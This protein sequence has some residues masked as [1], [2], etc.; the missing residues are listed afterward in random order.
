MILTIPDV[1]QGKDY[2]CG[3]AC[4][5]A[6]CGMNG[7]TSRGP[8]PLANAIQGL[9]PDTVEA[10]FRST[11]WTI[12]SG[13][14]TVDDLKHFADT[15]RPVMCPATIEQEGHWVVSAGV[16]RGRVH[17]HDPLHGMRSVR[18]ADWLAAWHDTSRSGAEYKQ[19]G[20]VA[21]RGK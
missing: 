13:T 1:R 12:L 19:W 21:W 5:D 4:Y 7:I 18:T 6:I 3:W 15:G 10:V 8:V 9:S 14:M 2:D 11:G 17:F 16:A 20:I